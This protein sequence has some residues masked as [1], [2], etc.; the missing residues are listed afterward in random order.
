MV[1]LEVR[2]IPFAFDDTVPFHWQ[3]SAPDVAVMLNAVGVLAIAFEK[4]IVASTRIA[5]PLIKD[6]AVA[7][8]AESF[9]RQEAQHANSH[10]KH[11]AALALTHPGLQG[12]VDKAVER[13]DALSFTSLQYQLAYTAALEATFTPTFKLFLD[14]ESELF[15]PGDERVASLFLWHFVEEVEHRSSALEIYDAVVGRPWYRTMV[16]PKVFRHVF[17]TYFQIIEGFVECVPGVREAMTPPVEKKEG[18]RVVQ[19]LGKALGGGRRSSLYDV[20]ST[21]ELLTTIYRLGLSQA[22]WHSPAGEPLPAF[23]GRWL[24]AYKAGRDVQF[25]YSVAGVSV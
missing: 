1:D 11:L 14:H 13:F 12:V 7:A 25:C 4:H 17:Q 19:L 6:K 20:A 9:L 8:E 16:A 23:A 3:P 2:R 22:P 10:R 24:D 5:I 18:G 15:R 21:R